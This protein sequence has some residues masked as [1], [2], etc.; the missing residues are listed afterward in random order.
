MQ[1]PRIS[2]LDH[3]VSEE[4]EEQ[5][6]PLIEVEMSF[7]DDMQEEQTSSQQFSVGLMKVELNFAILPAFFLYI[8]DG[9]EQ[10]PDVRTP[11]HQHF[12]SLLFVPLVVL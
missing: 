11:T 8:A 9:L 10:M 5:F 7:V 12:H 6:D 4:I 2:L 3:C 1:I